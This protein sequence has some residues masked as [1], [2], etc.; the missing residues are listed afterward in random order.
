MAE[1]IDVFIAMDS[2]GDYRTGVDMD[3]AI[4]DYVD[5]IGGNLPLRVV[6]LNV[7]MAKPDVTEVDVKVP[8]AAGEV[9]KAEAAE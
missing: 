6:K 3:E 2:D 8:D 9:V 1:T 4:Q 7:T 5:N